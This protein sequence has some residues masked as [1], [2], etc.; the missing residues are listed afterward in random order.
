MLRTTY[1]E[2]G[3]PPS[4]LS[5]SNT[6]RSGRSPP[7]ENGHDQPVTRSAEIHLQRTLRLRGRASKRKELC[8]PRHC[9]TPLL[10]LADGAAGQTAAAVSSEGRVLREPNLCAYAR[11][12]S[13]PSKKIW[14]E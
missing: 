2:R 4:G 8:V 7:S 5:S 1:D 9:E 3:L 10:A 6:P 11:V 13:A 14:A 12:N